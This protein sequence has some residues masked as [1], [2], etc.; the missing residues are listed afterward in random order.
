[1]PN[2]N[3]VQ[4]GQ[5]FAYSVPA[6]NLALPAYGGLGRQARIY[7]GIWGIIGDYRA[8]RKKPVIFGKKIQNK[9]GY[10]F[11]VLFLVINIGFLESHM[12]G[13]QANSP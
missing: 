10:P 2:Q 6:N 1:V 3:V 11:F 7:G 12:S 4:Y 8:T 13:R 5:H 9:N